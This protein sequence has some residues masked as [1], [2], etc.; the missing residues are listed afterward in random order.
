M[1]LSQKSLGVVVPVYNKE[2]SIKRAIDSIINQHIPFKA[3]FIVDDGSTDKSLSIIKTY[4]NIQNL[5]YISVINGGVSSARNIG[6]DKLKSLVD[7][8]LFL[9]ADDELLPNFTTTILKS[10]PKE[11]LVSVY[12]KKANFDY[13]VFVS[14][15][16]QLKKSELL[17]SWSRFTSP[18]WTGCTMV[19]TKNL[20]TQF[21]TLYNHGED[22]DFFLSC[23]DE[24]DI[25]QII[26]ELGTIYHDTPNSLSKKVIEPSHDAFYQKW[27][28]N[29]FSKKNIYVLKRILVAFKSKNFKI[30]L[31]WL[32]E[33]P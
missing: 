31:K 15:K 11:K 33:L 1:C 3:I 13:P 12:R 9:D 28:K 29:S 6:L 20:N 27:L 5:D 4:S 21:D 25:I 10:E 30:L 7:Y 22:R 26:P 2:A 32:K 14:T 17:K 24:G 23:L 8:I 19:K 16:S 18:I